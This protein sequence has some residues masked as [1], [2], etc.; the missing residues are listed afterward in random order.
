MASSPQ[1]SMPVKDADSYTLTFLGG[2]IAHGDRNE[3][4]K[5]LRNYQRHWLVAKGAVD[6]VKDVGAKFRDKQEKQEATIRECHEKGMP[7][8]GYV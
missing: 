5:Y 8:K 3:A 1:V 6:W 7:Y 4:V 2:G